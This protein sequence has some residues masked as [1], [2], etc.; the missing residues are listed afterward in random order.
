M[1][2]PPHRRLVLVALVPVVVAAGLGVTRT[3]GG[4]PGDLLG[5]VLYAALVYMLVG[6]VRPAWRIPVLVGVT[7]AMCAV[8]ELAQ[9]TGLPARAVELFSPARYVLGTTFTA[10]DLPAYAVGALLS[11]AV[12]VLARSNAGRQTSRMAATRAPVSGSFRA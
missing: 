8:V 9:L 2:H 12:D 10:H 6:A 7:F 3:V 5:G 11:G 4:L 1:P